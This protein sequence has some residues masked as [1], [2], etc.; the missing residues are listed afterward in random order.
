MSAAS[1]K[2]VASEG[3]VNACAIQRPSGD[4]RG[5]GNATYIGCP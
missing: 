5:Q 3:K 4:T 2:D 1:L